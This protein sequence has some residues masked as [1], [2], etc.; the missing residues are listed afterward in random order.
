MKNTIN[1][2]SKPAHSLHIQ[3]AQQLAQMILTEELTAASILP[4]EI[5]LC[6]QFNVS[7]TALREAIK[8]LTSK[9][10]L[11]SRPKVGTKVQPKQNWNFL[12]PQLLEWLSQVSSKKDIYRHFFHLRKA[13]EPEA[14][15]LAA[16]HATAEQRKELSVIFQKMTYLAKNFNHEG[17]T[18]NDL[19][20]H[21]IIFQS[22][23]NDFFLSFGNTLS[24]MMRNFL[25]FS[26][27]KQKVCYKEHLAIYNAIM[28]GD[29][30][31]A[32]QAATALFEVEKHKFLLEAS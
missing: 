24:S 25:Y 22:T 18:E 4:S 21:Q 23:G 7:R 10:L 31:L 30:L 17:W 5:V 14:C 12:D 3:I 2:A 6:E 16:L 13:I 26:S 8:L 15:S 32:K 27:E 19:K 9:G 28:A 1:I 11:S 20:F 29:A